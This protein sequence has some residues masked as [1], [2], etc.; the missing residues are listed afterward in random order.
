[1]ISS[2]YASLI[3]TMCMDLIFHGEQCCKRT[4]MSTTIGWKV[5]ESCAIF[6]SY[7]A[8]LESKREI[9]NLVN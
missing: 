1:M 3:L 9:D 7:F 5:S 2:L 4:S 6:S 8:I